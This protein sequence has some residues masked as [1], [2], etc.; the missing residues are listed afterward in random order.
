MR[1]SER[2][3]LGAVASLAGLAGLALPTAA[4][5]CATCFG[6]PQAPMT[7]GM[8]NAIL[9]LLGVVGLVYVGIGKVFWDFRK[10]S[11]KLEE[12]QPQR[13]RLRLIHGGKQ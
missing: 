11:K 2:N 6:D 3:V 5:A 7:H 9:T 1:R 4:A 8:N 12:Q 10:R 13:P